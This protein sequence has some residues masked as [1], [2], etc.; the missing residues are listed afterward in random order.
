[1]NAVFDAIVW[2]E[3]NYALSF[4]YPLPRSAIMYEK[5]LNLYQYR[6]QIKELKENELITY[7]RYMEHDFCEGYLQD[8][9]FVQ[10]WVLTRKGRKTEEYQKALLKAEEF[11]KSSFG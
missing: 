5:G 9:Y 2:W 3:A 8:S 7:T 10:G 1:M 6:K 4:G 11:F